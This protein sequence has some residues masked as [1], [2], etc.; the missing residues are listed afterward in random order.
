MSSRWCSVTAPHG[1]PLF[2]GGPLR[3]NFAALLRHQSLP[4]GASQ[5]RLTVCQSSSAARS[6]VTPQRRAC[7]QCLPD[8][9]LPQCHFCHQSL[10]DGASQRR[11]TICHS[12]SAARPE[13]TSQRR[14]CQLSLPHG[15]LPQCPWLA[16]SAGCP[17]QQL[18]HG[19]PGQQHLPDS[20]LPQCRHPLRH[21]A[22]ASNKP[23]QA[24]KSTP[25]WLAIWRTWAGFANSQHRD[26][27]FATPGNICARS[28]LLQH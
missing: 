1:L 6:E 12:S 25:V 3:S 10:P 11:L 15:S 28:S 4:D 5:R 26:A 8:G 24:E 22:P 19:T 18:R 16:A 17:Y 2:I 9:S 14:S 21:G 7:R 23:H 13:V 20:S 27:A